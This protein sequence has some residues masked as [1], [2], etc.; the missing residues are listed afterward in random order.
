MSEPQALSPIQPVFNISAPSGWFVKQFTT[1]LEPSG[2]ANVIASVE[3]IAVDMTASEYA[4][5]QGAVLQDEFPGYREHSELQAT[6][7][8]GVE[9]E[10]WYREFSWSPED[11]PPVRQA[12]LYCVVPG[13]GFTVTATVTEE[14]YSELR[15]SL[16]VIVGS[17]FVLPG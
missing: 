6:A 17:F 3:R 14:L 10:G 8:D 7:V 11:T 13:S 15:E 4:R 12:Q 5:L 9:Q 2:R 1:V 16:A